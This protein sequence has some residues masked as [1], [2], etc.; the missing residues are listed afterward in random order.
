MAVLGKHS[1]AKRIQSGDLTFSP[2]LDAFQMQPHA[3]D[4]RLGYRFLLPRNWKLD[5]EGRKA[6]TVSVET[7]ETSTDQFEEIILEPG[8]FFELLPNEFVIA[9]SLERIEMNALDLMGIL[10]PRTSTNRRG[11]DLSLSGIIDAGYKGHL[12]FPMKN[13]AGNQ[14]IRVYPGERICQVLF[15]ELDAPLT[16]KD[17]SLHGMSPAKYT[18]SSE[19]VYKLDKS[20]ERS[21][22]LLGEI[23]ELKKRFPVK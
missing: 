12:I 21:L 14:V 13:E 15:E 8:Q 5:H 18:E 10:F 6:I 20:E 4:L 3:I 7:V 9:T 16:L 19:V 22:L 11:I 17:A 1:I 2:S 23:D